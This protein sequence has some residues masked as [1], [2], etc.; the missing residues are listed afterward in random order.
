[1]SSL[2]EVDIVDEFD[3]MRKW[4]LENKMIINLEKL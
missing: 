1:V 2:S 4:E 3:N